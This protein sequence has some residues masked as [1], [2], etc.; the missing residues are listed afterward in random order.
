MHGA[1]SCCSVK[2]DYGRVCTVGDKTNGEDD[3]DCGIARQ[4]LLKMDGFFV[5]RFHIAPDSIFFVKENPK[6]WSPRLFLL[7]N[8]RDGV[9][10]DVDTDGRVDIVVFQPGV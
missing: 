2:V 3:A 7:N 8:D 9:P 1:I 5:N 6:R 4:H 10:H